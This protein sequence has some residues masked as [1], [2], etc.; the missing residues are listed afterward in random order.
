MT[1]HRF[2]NR[3]IKEQSPHLLQHAHNP[4]DWYPW[5]EEAFAQALAQ[6]RPI[7]LSIGYST[8]HLCH[9][10][11]RE[12]FNDEEI[13]KV[14]NET[15]V[16]IKVDREEMP[17]VDGLYMEFAQLMMPGGVG[18]PLSLVLSSD[19]RPFFAATYMPAKERTWSLGLKEIVERIRKLWNSPDRE[20][21]LEQAVQ[22][23]E[24]LAGNKPV[25]GSEL[26][27]EGLINH[28]AA[29]LYKT[30]DPIHGGLKGLPKFPIAHLTS[31]LLRHAH[32]SQD[33]RALFCAELTLNH[34]ERGGIHDHLGGGFSRY[35]IDDDWVIPHFEKMLYDNAL[36]AA[37]YLEAWQ[38]TNEPFYKERCESTLHYLLR[39]MADPEGGFYS[40]EDA[41]LDGQEGLYYTWT[42]EE[43]RHVLGAKESAL[44]CSYY[45]VTEQGNFHDRNVLH[46]KSSLK[47][48]SEKR[49]LRMEDLEDLETYFKRCCDL[50]YK[51]RCARAS[52]LKD[53]QVVTGWNGLMIHAL[54][55][56]SSVLEEPRYLEM[57]C[58]A[59]QFIKTNMWKEGKLLR[60]WRLGKAIHPACLE[61]Y[62][63]LIHGL[64]S[65]FEAD[66]GTKWL[67]WAVQ[68]TSILE[69]E[70]KAEGGA[71][72]T[73]DGK[74]SALIF[75][76]CSYYDG[77]EPS[78]NGVHCEN[79]LRLYQMTLEMRYLKQA[80]DVLRAVQD[81]LEQYSVGH[82]YHLLAL[83]RY[84]DEKGCSLVIALNEKEEMKEEI[85]E[86]L[87]HELLPHKTVVWRRAGD[88]KL[89]ELFPFSR[90]QVAINGKTTI[91]VCKHA[92]CLEPM[93]DLAEVRKALLKKRHTPSAY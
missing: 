25:V 12:S 78:G 70:F 65:L 31:F 53:D 14:L 88:E 10:M 47:E 33:S 1:R 60:C 29:L 58:K 23:T 51:E 20:K 22:I 67:E 21:V 11:E 64:L 41:E 71:F 46:I 90:K 32:L 37:T 84:Y 28:A 80:E 8:C 19:R 66:G 76:R 6:G 68:L 57:A 30:I 16:N 15:F 81:H 85:R 9:M 83:Q 87:R 63:F 59:A 36:L 74:D 61:D 42:V 89:F 7:F 69:K 27:N 50:L 52:P 93:T 18:W 45:E 92:Q 39:D 55:N 73:T 62:A 48:F 79:L 75:R 38:L 5:G 77:A 72:Y 24:I 56:A 26:P 34:L 13:A 82:S 3:L 44:F 49:N 91:Y 4:V 43:I 35:S 2:T 40:G 17:E 86:M 54:A